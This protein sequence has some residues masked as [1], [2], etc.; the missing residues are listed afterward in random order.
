M[1]HVEFDSALLA[2]SSAATA[3]NDLP[4]IG[5][6][7]ADL[8]AI[9][10][11]QTKDTGKDWSA[12]TTIR[13]TGIDSFDFVELVFEVED[14]YGIDLKFNANT[15]EDLKTVSDV[16]ELIHARLVARSHA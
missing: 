12:T 2:T 7:I 8:I 10:R 15:S 6:I 4:Q 9:I 13:E 11:T 14:K 5:V 16:A 3:Q 1:T